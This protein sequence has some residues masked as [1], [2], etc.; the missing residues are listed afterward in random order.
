MLKKIM[1]C[2]VVL[3]VVSCSE[4]AD[5]KT[6][7]IAVPME[8]IELDPFGT[9]DTHSI[10]I[11]H[12]VFDTPIVIGKDGTYQPK[13][14]T[15]WKFV[16]PTKLHLTI[17]S[18]VFFHNGD[19]LTAEDVA[20]S[21][22]KSRATPTHQSD[23]SPIKNV[24]ATSPYDVYVELHFP[25]AP[26]LATLSSGFVYIVNKKE[27]EAGNNYV[28]T[29]PFKFKEWNR[30]RNVV[31]ERFDDYWGEVAKVEFIDIRTVPES[32]VR[33]IAAETG[34]VDIAYDIDY[35]EKE[36]AG[37]KLVFLETQISRIE[38]LG[39]NVTEKP[40]DNPKVRE[41]IAYALDVPGIISSA[42]QG[43]GVHANSLSVRGPGYT[44]S[45]PMQQDVEKARQLFI[46]SGVVLD[47]PLQILAV[48]GIRKL[49]AEIIQANLKE[50]GI[51]AEVELVEWAKYAQTMYDVDTTMFLGGWSGAPDADF[52]YNVFFNSSNIGSGGNFT[53]YS[54]PE[55]DRL[56][57]L[58][59]VEHNYNKRQQL[60][61]QIHDKT[62]EEKVLVPLYYPLNTLVHRKNISGIDFNTYM[63]HE[64]NIIEKN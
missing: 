39:F 37:D 31:I 13:L 10:R 5:T 12:Q 64:W 34:E 40:Y 55:M 16:T 3:S 46:E 17:R 51:N 29:G 57:G 23:L 22:N 9:M 26:V 61:Q 53:E 48:D 21:L 7:T 11:R 4:S 62:I 45:E 27:S 63:L 47:K 19:E 49:T 52:Y 15:D 41:A 2:L 50:I 24:E 20:Y 25:Y 59:R 38:Y 43:A 56:L 1:L 60:Y 32:L 42:A 54:D 30:G 58:A 14:A 44:E 33:M 8:M 28:G 6:L 36:R 18:N 35:G